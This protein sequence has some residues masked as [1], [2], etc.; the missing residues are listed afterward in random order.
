MANYY[1][2]EAMRAAENDPWEYWNED[3]DEIREE[4]PDFTDEYYEMLEE[5]EIDWNYEYED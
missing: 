5:E 2:D 1:V 3:L 4:D